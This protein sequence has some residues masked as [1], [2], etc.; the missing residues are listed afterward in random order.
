MLR[1]IYN[2]LFQDDKC[3]RLTTTLK[4]LRVNN[5]CSDGMTTLL[6]S[7][8]KN[9]PEDQPI[10]LLHILESNGVEHCFWAL[11]ATKE[12]PKKVIRLIMIDVVESIRHHY[13]SK[14][15]DSDVIKNVVKALK[16]G[17]K[18]ELRVAANAATYAANATAN[19]AYATACAAAY[20]ANAAA[21]AAYAAAERQKQ[22][23]IIK[24][25]LK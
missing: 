7:L 4:L 24:K 19:A 14:Y 5:A 16:S 13:E 25:Y 8:P 6:K 15:P 2:V 21:D 3:T 9:Y 12:C 17:D 23:E 11:R 22:I 10:N 1:T 20:A 18:E